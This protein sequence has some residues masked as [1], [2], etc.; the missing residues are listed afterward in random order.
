M[1]MVDKNAY[2]STIAA[3][4]VGERLDIRPRTSVGSPQLGASGK[5]QVIAIEATIKLT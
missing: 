5:F 3:E 2:S 4:A 1:T